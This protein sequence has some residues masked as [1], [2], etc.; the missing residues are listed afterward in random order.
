MSSVEA[1]LS[2]W[3]AQLR[4]RANLPVLLQW[5]ED[6]AAG[7]GLRLGEFDQPKVVIRVRKAAAVPLLLSPSLDSLGEAYVEGLIDVEGSVDDILEMAHALA[8]AGAAKGESRLARIARHFTHTKKSDQEA[9]QYHYDVSNEFYQAWLD[10][11]M[12]YSCA[13]FENGDETLEQAQLKKID[14]IL[15]KVQLQPGQ[16]LL[17]IGCGWGA[18]VMRAAEKYGAR[19]V[20]IT[21]SQ[22]QFEL[23][24]ERVRAAGL[25]DRVEI[26]LQDYRDVQG[27]FDRITSVGMFEH[28]GLDYLVPYFARIREL[29]T[30]DGWVLNHG[31]TSTDPND[32]ETRHGGG[33]FIDRYVF[34]QGELPHISTVLKTM[35]EGG[36]EALD[37]ESLR[38]HY[39]RTTALWSQAFEAQGERLQQMVDQKHWRIWRVYLAGCAWAFDHDEISIYQVLCRKA[40]RLAHG[41]PWSRRWMYAR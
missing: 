33:R 12:V 30:D 32:G 25:Q 16:R 2:P 39:A 35:Q 21:L 34:P 1:M 5:G 28:V 14:H 11:R 36:L 8:E 22:R 10:P 13:Y 37:V 26:R 7:A 23:A 18:L 31:I 38:R 24:S 3:V 9:I 29:L 6:P 19:C 15:T 20:G 41:L 40:G 17:D 4:S 27:Q